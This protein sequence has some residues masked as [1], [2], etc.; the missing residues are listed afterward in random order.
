MNEKIFTWNINSATNRSISTPEFV[1]E[2]IERQDSDFLILTEFCKTKNHEEFIQK[3]LVDNGYGYILSN[4][5]SK[6][7]DILIAWKR[8]KYNA[9]NE[10]KGILT[11]ETTPNFAYVVLKD[12]SGFEFV[13]AGVRITIESYEN[14]AKQYR[15]V[16]DSL[17][18][19]S[20]VVIG[21]DFNCLRRGTTEQRWN[22]SLLSEMS[23]Q[24]EFKLI[25]PNGQ[26]IYAEKAINTAYEFAEDHFVVKGMDLTNEIYDRSFTDRNSNIYLHGRNFSVYDFG[27]KRN[28]WSINVGSGIPDHAILSATMNW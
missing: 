7:N 20:R 22:I 5:L 13:L 12:S 6:H 4:N 23:R 24:A 3:H 15:F 28:I 2:E 11:N 1:G 19:F 27:L 17:K 26:S 25:T 9:V 21:G 14:R 10:E 16:L 8:D 18:T